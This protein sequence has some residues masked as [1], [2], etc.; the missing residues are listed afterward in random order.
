[1]IQQSFLKDVNDVKSVKGVKGVKGVNGAKDSIFA[2]KDFF[3]FIDVN[4]QPWSGSWH[5]RD[6][7]SWALTGDDYKTYSSISTK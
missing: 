5:T 1:M 3:S 4:H 2:K 6:R 7:Q